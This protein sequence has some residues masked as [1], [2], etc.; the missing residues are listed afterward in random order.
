MRALTGWLAAIPMLFAQGADPL[1]LSE[2]LASVEKNYPPLLAALQE[3]PLAEADV[4]SALGRFDILA[5]A[6]GD[7][8]ELGRVFDDRRIDTGIEQNTALWG[9]SYFTG[10]RYSAGSFASYD[11]KLLTG[12]GGEYRAGLRLPLARDRAIDP[13]RADA[14]K[15]RVGLR[16]AD[17]A[18][19][20]QRIV[21]VQSATRRYWEW[22]A[23]GQRYTVAQAALQIAEKRDGFL[24]ESVDAGALPAIDITDNERVI[25]QRR[26]FGVEARRGLEQASIE[27]SLFYRDG[28]GDPVVPPPA[29]L[30]A[31]FPQPA[32]IDDAR[33]R[34]DV[35][36]ALDRRPEVKRFLAQRDQLDIER[37]LALNQQY[38]GVDALFSYA[39]QIGSPAGLRGPDELR[40]TLNFELPL[41]RRQARGREEA[42]DARIAQVDQRTRFQRDQITAEV[43]DAVSAVRAAFERTGVLAAE[44]KATQQVET[45]ERDR[46]ELGESTLFTLNLREIATV[47]ARLREAAAQADYFRALALYELAI[48]QALAPQP[49]P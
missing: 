30:P 15:A 37:R 8:D 14:A 49:K 43:Q 18:I 11:G 22:V 6:R 20:Q 34:S 44:V 41:Q 32:A 36:M 42:A 9:L 45:A 3:R 48:A 21:I 28:A 47:D 26:G 5:R 29:R 13:R 23:A 25:F 7:V 31:A 27:L 39:R 2:V 35:E 24:R 46:Y 10:Y 19:D 40:W 16:L 33:L 1:E 4:L 17:L 38:P 12:R